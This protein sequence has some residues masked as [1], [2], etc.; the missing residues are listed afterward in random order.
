MGGKNISEIKNICDYENK[1]N[2]IKCC[3]YFIHWNNS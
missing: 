1:N 2:I 3:V